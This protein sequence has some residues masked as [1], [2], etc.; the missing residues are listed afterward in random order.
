MITAL[1]S[2]VTRPPTYCVGGLM[3]TVAEKQRLM[4]TYR[5]VPW[6]RLPLLFPDRTLD[7]IMSRASILRIPRPGKHWTPEEDRLLVELRGR[8]LSYREMVGRFEARSLPALRN[9]AYV[10][11]K[12]GRKR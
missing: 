9:R 7:A 3:W 12:G 2:E 6:D 1:T 4:N 5:R 11:R 10:L 8:G